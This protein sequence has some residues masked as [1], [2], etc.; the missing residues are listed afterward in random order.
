MVV[1]I[2]SR[3]LFEVLSCSSFYNSISFWFVFYFPV[4]LINLLLIIKC[5]PSHGSYS[6][7]Y[8]PIEYPVSGHSQTHS[9]LQS[10]LYVNDFQIYFTALEFSTKFWICVPNHLLNI[11]TWILLENFKP[12]VTHHNFLD[13]LPT[14]SAF[15]IIPVFLSGI[16]RA[17]TYSV[18]CWTWFWFNLCRVLWIS[19]LFSN[20]VAFSLM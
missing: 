15:L 5:C 7:P 2:R 16:F 18:H 10:Y 8:T 1:I 3:G 19:P 9:R 20:S 11:A 12:I 6:Q 14:H 17:T 4:S 13:L